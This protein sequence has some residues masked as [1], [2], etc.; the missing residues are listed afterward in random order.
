MCATLFAAYLGNALEILLVDATSAEDVT[1]GKVLRAQI[2]NR[3]ARQ[4]HLCI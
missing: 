1:V 3:Q 2:A 4:H